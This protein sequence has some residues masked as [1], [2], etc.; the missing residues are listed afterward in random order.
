MSVSSSGTERLPHRTARRPATAPRSV[1]PVC[2]RNSFLG[3][4]VTGPVLTDRNTVVASEIL[5]V[6]T[7][8]IG[9]TTAVD[10]EFVAV[11]V[12]QGVSALV[13]VGVE[14][15]IRFTAPQL[16]LLRSL[17]VLRAGEQ[18]TRRDTGLGEAVVVGPAVKR[19]VLRR[20]SSGVEVGGQRP[21]DS[22]GAL[23][24]HRI[25][26]LV[27]RQRLVAVVG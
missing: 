25:A 17:L 13:V 24:N 10:A 26:P 6:Q 4:L 3:Q 16:G 20:L 14:R 19:R 11:D 15:L 21:L 1:C 12:L 7:G 9:D 23:G 22:G 8:R 18:A 27:S 2:S 5:G